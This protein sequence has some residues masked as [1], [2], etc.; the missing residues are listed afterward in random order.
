[1]LRSEISSF[2]QFGF[3]IDNINQCCIELGCLFFI[4]LHP[5]NYL[6]NQLKSLVNELSNIYIDET[7]DVYEHLS[8]Y[9]LMITDFSSIFF[10]GLALD[11]PSYLSLSGSDD[12]IKNERQLYV[13]PYDVFD[14]YILKDWN[15]LKQLISNASVID[16]DLS[17]YY[18]NSTVNIC[19]NLVSK[20]NE[21]I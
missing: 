18:D 1:M 16:K 4:R 10:D 2:D 15:S 14:G 6:S 17:Y 3:S 12:Y 19:D 21:I 8:E 20:I 9:K 13:N 5:A 11:V 7:E